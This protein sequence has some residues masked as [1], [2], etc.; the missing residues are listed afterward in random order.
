MVEEEVLLNRRI[1][2]WVRAGFVLLHQLADHARGTD[3]HVLGADFSVSN[4]EP[5]V[6]VDGLALGSALDDALTR[7][8]VLVGFLMTIIEDRLDTILF[9]PDDRSTRTVVV[10]VPA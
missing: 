5:L 10:V 8:V 2:I 1:A 4:R 3:K 6:H 7:V 9:V